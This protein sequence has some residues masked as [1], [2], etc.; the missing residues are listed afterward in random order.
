MRVATK[1]SDDSTPEPS[2]QP[3]EVC[4]CVEEGG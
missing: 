1:E 2:I 3:S 4:I